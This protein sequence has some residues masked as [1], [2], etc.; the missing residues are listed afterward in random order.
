MHITIAIGTAVTSIVIA[1]AVGYQI[2]RSAE[3]RRIERVHQRIEAQRV[4]AQARLEA[5][6]GR[7]QRVENLKQRL[8]PWRRKA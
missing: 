4:K 5:K 2:G 1:F 8:L 7:T 6:Q 3:V